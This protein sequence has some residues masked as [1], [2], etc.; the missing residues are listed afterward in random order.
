LNGG[1]N[2][3]D[4]VD[5]GRDKG[6]NELLDIF[7]GNESTKFGEGSSGGFLD[8]SL[9]VPDSVNHNGND[10]RHLSST[11]IG[12]TLNQLINNFQTSSLDLPLSSSLDLFQKDRKEDGSSPGS[13]DLND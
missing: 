8:V 9:G 13:S 5:E 1:R 2:L 3:F 6:G 12:S 7:V 10:R 4:G 11:L